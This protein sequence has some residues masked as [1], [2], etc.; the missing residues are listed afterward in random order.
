MKKLVTAEIMQQLDKIVI[1]DHG[2]KST[3]LMENAAQ[4]VF[5][6][7]V[8]YENDVKGKKVTIICGKVNKYGKN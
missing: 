2:V 5:E 3:T 7:I 4:Q 6:K 8:E 1:E